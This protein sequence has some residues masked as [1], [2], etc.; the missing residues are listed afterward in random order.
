MVFNVMSRNCDDHSKNFS[1]LL[2]DGG[3]WELAPAYD[4]T[5]AHSPKSQWTHQH[6]MS[7][8]GKYKDISVADVM[9][10]ADRFSI[11]EATSIIKTVRNAIKNWPS[12]AAKA[13]VEQKE[14]KRIGKLHV[15]L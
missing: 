5:F 2:R 10:V 13:G 6:L 8:N 15:L 9:A 12:F 11:G 14:I 1:F 4:V 3:G 7:V